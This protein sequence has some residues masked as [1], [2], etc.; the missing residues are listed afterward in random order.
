MI[1]AVDDRRFEIGVGFLLVAALLLGGASSV[2]HLGRVIVQLAA[3]PLLWMAVVRLADSTIAPAARNGL[4]LLGLIL[5]L[6]LVQLVPLPPGLWTAMPGRSDVTEIFAAMGVAPGWMGIS[7]LPDATLTSWLALIPAAT[8]F[9]ATL[10]LPEEGRLRLCFAVIGVALLSV[11]IGTI[12][13]SGGGERVLYFYDNTNVGSAVGF[14]SNRNHLATLLLAAIPLLSLLF[15]SAGRVALNRPAVIGRRIAAVSVASILVVGILFTGS[16]AGLVLLI[17]TLAL[18]Y[19]ATM[20]S[21]I[22]V[23]PLKLIFAVMAAGVAAI[24]IVVY[25]PFYERIMA[26]SASVEDEARVWAAPITFDAGWQVFPFGSGFGSFDAM[27]RAAAGDNFLTSSYVNHA[28]NDYL[29]LWLTGG[30]PAILLLAAVLWWGVRLAIANWRLKPGNPSAISRAA[31]VVVLIVLLH[32]IVDYP[33]R[34]VAISCLFAVAAALQLAPLI[35]KG[36]M[37]ADASIV[38]APRQPSSLRRSGSSRTRW[39]GK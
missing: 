10:T 18:T 33:V 19:A 35:P 2:G 30:L 14:F 16:R 13:V 26:R 20:R 38:S 36:R 27:F 28:H 34:T 6:P 8:L 37:L 29:E 9:I 22:G 23:P 17:P 5:M 12:Q 21:S 1:R 24:A 25:G 4:I 15:R 11:L 32:S 3:L 31:S 7:L 39:N